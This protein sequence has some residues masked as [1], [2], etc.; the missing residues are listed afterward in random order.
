M[1]SERQSYR[2]KR[3]LRNELYS[4][5]LVLAAPVGVVAVFPCSALSFR[6]AHSDAAE[7]VPRARCSFIALT[8]EQADAA[9]QAARAAIRTSH[10]GISALR[11]D[12][13]ISAIPSE[14]GG[15]ADVTERFGVA[16]MADAV[17]DAPPMPP[18]LAAPPPEKITPEPAGAGPADAFSREDLL[19][20]RD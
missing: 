4:L 15:V 12:L 19:R 6:P 9:V 20:I 1:G 3:H 2:P 13:S 18:T 14:R 8:Q 7:T 10:E 16:P 17:Y 5:A 11:A